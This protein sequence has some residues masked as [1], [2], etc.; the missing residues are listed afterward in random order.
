MVLDR[1]GN[2]TENIP[3]LSQQ[4]ADSACLSLSDFVNANADYIGA[5]CC[6]ASYESVLIQRL[7]RA[8][9]RQQLANTFKTVCDKI[10]E[11]CSAATFNNIR[12]HF[13]GFLDCAS[14]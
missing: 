3:M 13:W 4:R 9:G 10:V 1:L 12:Q 2:P 14:H 8:T 5:F 11:E 7:F 6:G